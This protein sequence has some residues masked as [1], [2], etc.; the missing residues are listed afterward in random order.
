MEI[1]D[2]GEIVFPGPSNG[3]IQIIGLSLNVRLTILHVIC[4][5]S[6][7]NANMVQTSS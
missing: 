1:Y 2:D 6:D 3:S 7:R 5:K 4:P